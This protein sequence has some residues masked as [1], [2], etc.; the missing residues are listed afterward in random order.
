M[1]EAVARQYIKV[2]FDWD[3]STSELTLEEKGRLID[4]LIAYA[5]GKDYTISGNERFVFPL[6]RLQIDR[7]ALAYEEIS[8][9]RKAAGSKG[10]KQKQAN[11]ANANNCEQMQTNLGKPSQDQDQ[12]QDQDKDQEQYSADTPNRK[13]LCPPS[14]VE[15]QEYMTEY[16][17]QHNM[18]IDTALQAEKFFNYHDARG[19]ILGSTKKTMQRWKS[20]ANTWMCNIRERMQDEPA[21]KQ[22]VNGPRWG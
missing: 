17:T 22:A 14:L 11:V 13:R 12:D 1:R 3:E 2:F 15:I 9:K 4:S 8:E 6:F 10:G 19:W 18:Q 21:V 7:D 5:Q 20:A 16:A